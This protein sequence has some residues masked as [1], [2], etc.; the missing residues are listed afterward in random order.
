VKSSPEGLCFACEGPL[1]PFVG[2]TFE[3]LFER[4]S[5]CELILRKRS[6]QL[7]SEDALAF[8]R[9]HQ[10]DVQDEGY[11]RFLSKVTKPLIVR[12]SSGA[13]GLDYGSGP[14]PALTL[15][16]SEAGFETLAYDPLFA[17]DGS[18]LKRTYDFVTATEVVE[19]FCDPSGDWAS[20]FSLIRPRGLLAVMTEWYRGQQPLSAWRYARDPTHNVFYTRVALAQIAR[21]FGADVEFP[22]DNVCIFQR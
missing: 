18:L 4:C 6:Q 12:L 2:G 8:Y 9:T 5:S 1:E 16:M 10:N 17:P 19:H 20:M 3:A 22:A 13:I 15:L 11:R 7:N 21:H 14:A